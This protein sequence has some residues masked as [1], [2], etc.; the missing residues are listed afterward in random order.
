LIVLI[1]TDNICKELLH[2]KRRLPYTVR[3]GHRKQLDIHIHLLQ[4]IRTLFSQRLFLSTARILLIS[5]DENPLRIGLLLDSLEL[6]VTR[7][8]RLTQ[9]GALSRPKIDLIREQAILEK[10][11]TDRIGELQLQGDV[12]PLEPVSIVGLPGPIEN[13]AD[14]VHIRCD[15]LVLH[16][17]EAGLEDVGEATAVGFTLRI[18][19]VLL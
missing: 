14:L 12:D 1:N 10:L 2:I 6:M 17:A 13:D 5:K 19:L 9:L 15:N 3:P 16:K 7:P 18:V 4:V 11:D 8:Q